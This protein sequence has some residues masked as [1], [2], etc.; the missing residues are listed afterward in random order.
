MILG[1]SL[2]TFTTIHV[3]ISL[4]AAFYET[5]VVVVPVRSRPLMWCLSKSRQFFD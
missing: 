1:M 2:A 3:I 5:V 4:I